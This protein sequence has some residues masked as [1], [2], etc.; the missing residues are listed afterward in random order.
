VFRKQHKH[1]SSNKIH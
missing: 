1:F